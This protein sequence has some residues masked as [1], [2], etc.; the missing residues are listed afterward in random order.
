MALRPVRRDPQ[1]A[2][3]GLPALTSASSASCSTTASATSSTTTG[4]PER[5]TSTNMM[6]PT[7]A[8]AT[9]THPRREMGSPQRAFRC[10]LA[11]ERARSRAQIDAVALG[12]RE[13]PP[14]RVGVR[15]QSLHSAKCRV[16]PYVYSP[17]RPD[18]EMTHRLAAR[19]RDP[20]ANRRQ[21]SRHSH[22]L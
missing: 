14:E 2:P 9:D 13:A 4:D 6:R 8:A 5:C 20:P 15:A 22:W 10:R 1:L 21:R 18:Q 11:D 7:L 19:L 3:V 12:P 16:E 17:V